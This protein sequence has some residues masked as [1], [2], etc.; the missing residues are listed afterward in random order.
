MVEESSQT[1]EEKSDPVPQ[2][3]GSFSSLPEGTYLAPLRDFPLADLS[4]E[5][6]RQLTEF[7]SEEF[8]TSNLNEFVD[9]VED[10]ELR[11]PI[12]PPL[13]S[14]EGARVI[15]IAGTSI[16]KELVMSDVSLNLS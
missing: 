11:T 7:T 6:G 1:F 15:S 5:S 2:L 8:Q 16:S 4:G 9:S 13:T 10:W 14:L 3:Q 12:A